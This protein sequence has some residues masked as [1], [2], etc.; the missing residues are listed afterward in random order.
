MGGGVV[1]GLEQEYGGVECGVARLGEKVQMG[2]HQAWVMRG[3]WAGWY[4]WASVFCALAHMGQCLG[5]SRSSAPC[6]TYG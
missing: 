4:P 1:L 2:K 6:F 3:S 5:V